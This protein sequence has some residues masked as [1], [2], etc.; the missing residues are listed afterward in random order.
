VGEDSLLPLPAPATTSKGRVVI[1]RAALA[2]ESTQEPPRV[3][4]TITS[5]VQP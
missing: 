3:E 5:I 2:H 1:D 4:G